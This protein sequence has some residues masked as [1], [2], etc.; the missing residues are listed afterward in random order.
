MS[1]K[2]SSPKESIVKRKFNEVDLNRKN[3]FAFKD[4]KV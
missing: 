2:T 1:T 3:N 4:K